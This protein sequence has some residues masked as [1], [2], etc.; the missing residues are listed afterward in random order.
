MRARQATRKSM[1]LKRAN[2]PG[3]KLVVLEHSSRA[4]KGNRLGDPYVRKL[5]VWLPAEY[6]QRARRGLGKRF[7]VLWDLVGF[8]GSG[9]AH[10]NWKPFSDNVPERVARLIHNRKMGAALVVFPEY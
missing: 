3:G 6:D 9:L 8:T 5:G 1:T 4:L 10:A 7:P 2:G